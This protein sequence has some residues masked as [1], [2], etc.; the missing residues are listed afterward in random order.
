MN[1]TDGSPGW[2]GKEGP[3]GM[4]GPIGPQGPAGAKGEAGEPGKQGPPGTD[5]ILRVCNCE[6][7]VPTQVF[8][9]NSGH[10]ISEK[11]MTDFQD[12]TSAEGEFHVKVVA[13]VTYVLHV[14]GKLEIFVR[15]SSRMR[16]FFSFRAK[17]HQRV[18]FSNH[19]LN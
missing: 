13:P 16:F 15:L 8:Y 10:W 4:R 18:D 19:K 9:V 2:R 7:N 17:S 12:V 5:S 1:G 6:R 11:A 3:R 14:G